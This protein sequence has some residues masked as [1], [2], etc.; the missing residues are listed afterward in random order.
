[1]NLTDNQLVLLA[2][3]LGH[4]LN[5]DGP[6]MDLAFEVLAEADRRGLE[7]KIVPLPLV[8]STDHAYGERAVLHWAGFAGAGFA[9][10]VSK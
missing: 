8:M 10:E 6:L 7:E 1:M 3:L 9:P 2:S 5:G 4:H